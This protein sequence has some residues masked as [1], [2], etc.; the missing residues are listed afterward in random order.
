[1]E[2]SYRMSVRELCET[3]DLAT[4]LVLDPLL[5]FSTHKMNIS[6]PPE[7]RRWGYLR[8]TLLRFK[9]THDF[10]ATFD[11]LLDGE[12]VSGYFTGL[13]SHRQELLKQHM[14]RYMTAFLL[15]SGVN[16]EPCNRYSSETN[17]AKI[18]STRH[19]LVGE[20]VEVLQGCIAELS[21][22]DSAVLRAGVND[23]SV[24]Y[25]MRKRC[26]QLWLGPAAFI[27]HDCR[28]NCKFVPGDKNGACVKVVRPISPGDE[29]TCYYGDSFF[30]ENNEMC[31]C[32]TCERR[33]E[34]SFKKR[35][36]SPDVACSVDPS[37]Q[38]YEFRETDLRLN[39]NRGNG[40]PKPFLTVSNSALPMRNTFSQRTKRNALVLSKMR[41][42]DRWRREEQCKQVEKRTQNLLSSLPHLELKELSI[43]LYQH[44]TNFLLSCK[45]PLS[46]ERA[47]LYLTEKERPKPERITRNSKSVSPPL[48]SANI[49]GP[50]ERKDED[51]EMLN[52]DP[53]I[54]FK[55]FTL[56]CVSS[57]HERDSMKAKGRNID[58]SSV[59]IVHQGISSRTR[60]ILRSRLSSLQARSRS[61]LPRFNKRRTRLIKSNSKL[62]TG[63]N[64]CSDS[65]TQDGKQQKGSE[66]ES[67][68]N[69][70]P[71]LI[72]PESTVIRETQQRVFRDCLR[73][74][75]GDGRHISGSIAPRAGDVS[76]CVASETSGDNKQN[77][78]QSVSS[79][80]V[81]VTP[82]LSSPSLNSPVSLLSGLNRYLR[83]SLE[84]VAIPGKPEVE[85]TGQR[86]ADSTR[87][88]VTAP[89]A[90][91]VQQS[92]NFNGSKESNIQGKK[93][94]KELYFTPV[95][96]ESAE[97]YLKVTCDLETGKNAVTQPV[98]KE[99]VD[100]YGK[101]SHSEYEIEGK[102]DDKV[103]TVT[104]VEVTIPKNSEDAGKKRKGAD[105]DKK[106][107][108]VE[109][110]PKVQDK[111][112][113]NKKQEEVIVEGNYLK[114]KV[115]TASFGSRTVVV[116]E[117]R[118][119]LMDIRKSLSCK[120]SQQDKDANDHQPPC[121]YSGIGEADNMKT[122]LLADNKE[123]KD[124]HD[125]LNN[126]NEHP[127]QGLTAADQPNI[128]E[129]TQEKQSESA[130]I[131]SEPP[132]MCMV[133][134]DHSPQSSI[135]LKKRA[136]RESL[137]TDPEQDVNVPATPCTDGSKGKEPNSDN[138]LP[139][140]SKSS[141]VDTTLM[142]CSIPESSLTLK[143]NV[144]IGSIKR[145]SSKLI[146]TS[147]KQYCKG[148]QSTHR[149]PGKNSV[150]V[151]EYRDSTSKVHVCERT[152][153]DPK[154]EITEAVK[155][156]MGEENQAKSDKGLG[157]G[158]KGPGDCEITD[159]IEHAIKDE[160]STS[161]DLD[162]TEEE[163]RLN[164]R[165]RLKRKRGKEWAMECTDE[166]KSVVDQSS[167]QQCLA[168]VDP[169]SA[170]LDTVSILNAEM[171]RIRGH[172]EADNGVGLEKATKAVQDVLE[173]CRKECAAKP[174]KRQQKVSAVH[175]N[176]NVSTPNEIVQD[177]SDV[178]DKQVQQK[179]SSPKIEAD[180]DDIKPLPLIR[181]CRRAEGKWEV[182]WKEVQNE[183]GSTDTLHREPKKLT[184][185]FSTAAIVEQMPLGKVK[186]ENPSQCQQLM[187]GRSCTFRDPLSFET[188]PLPISLSLLSLYS[189][190]YD[191]LAGVSNVS[192][193]I[194]A[195]DNVREHV[196]DSLDSFKTGVIRTDN[197]GRDDI[198]LSHNLFQI[199]K[200]LS[201]LQALSQSQVCEK[202][203]PTNTSVTSSQ[204][205]SPSISPFTTECSFSN[206]SEDVLDFPCLN[207]E[208]YDQMPA[209]NNLASS[210]IDYCPGEPH[211]TGSFSS[212]FSQSPT[213]AWNPETP[214]LGSPSPVSNFSSGEELC[215][216]D[217]VF[218]QSDTSSSIGASQL[219]FKDKLCNTATSSAPLQDPEKDLYLSDGELSKTP[220][221]LQVQEDSATQFLPKD[222][223]MFNN[224]S[225]SAKQPGHSTVRIHPQDKKL[226]FLD[227]I[228]NTKSSES[229]LAKIDIKDKIHGPLNLHSS[230]AKSE[231]VFPNLSTQSLHGAGPH[232]NLVTPFHSLHVGNKSTSLADYPGAFNSGNALFRSSDKKLPFF[233][234]PKNISKTEEGQNACR[235]SVAAGSSK[236]HNNME[237]IYACP[238][239]SSS[240]SGK[241]SSARC[242][243]AE[244]SRL[245]ENL[246][247]KTKNIPSK[248]YPANPG[249]QG[250][251]IHPVY[252]ISSS[253]TTTNVFKNIKPQITRNDKDPCLPSTYLFSS[254]QGSQC[255][256]T[257]QSKP[258]RLE[259]PH[260]VV[261]P[262][263]NTQLS[264][265]SSIQPNKDQMCSNISHCDS[266]AFN[267]SSSLS[268]PASQHS[269]PRLGYRESSVPEVPLFKTQS[270][271]FE[272]GQPP[273]QSYVVNFT[274]D[275]S[276]TLGYSEDGGSLNYTGSGPANYTYH[277][278][279]EPS[280]TQGRLV[281]EACG[282]S[283]FSPSPSASRFAGSKVHGGQVSRDQQHQGTGTHPCNSLHFSTS[284]SQSTPITDRKPKRLRLV[285]TDGTVDLD[286]Q[287]AD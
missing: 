213:D 31:E 118:V 33:G 247:K 22:E 202:S 276:V 107:K 262:T 165:I 216:P 133:S 14:Y 150:R 211:N 217:I 17:G 208:S 223:T 215:F 250:D 88:K 27:N 48:S 193:S 2:G 190:C 158:N 163:Q 140:P 75:A 59:R 52:E 287:Y 272:H 70:N 271:T 35:D 123:T 205:Q 225:T 54:R 125:A 173:H 101:D 43:C 77:H 73:E 72:S 109:S 106:Q 116:K 44:S 83:V 170:I 159:N 244:F 240:H 25:S 234:N 160:W 6:P 219:L 12:W 96:M 201:K 19:W 279:M 119:L 199:N 103:V 195:K 141:S 21:P 5:G 138:L 135:P 191:G 207:L 188:S 3:D 124:K 20:R 143:D 209:Q 214:Y 203:V 227:S 36:Q 84:R 78:R 18:T 15:D 253:K 127:N 13:G 110:V 100:V 45:D 273:H 251:R 256:S 178:T 145:G 99:L 120:F 92:T 49:N 210:L 233:P 51:G 168:L 156:N 154:S 152:I 260:A 62:S 8:G 47:L 108:H 177:S 90:A 269:S 65:Q 115:L 206:Y 164:V 180:I 286:L 82:S 46:K 174:C 34:G 128:H 186:E 146:K 134:L 248:Q 221:E 126:K 161:D 259:K 32:C 194:Q 147:A 89:A 187:A 228:I 182:E 265:V 167:P 86:E 281:V 55:P 258:S 224:A 239:P 172:G 105:K 197:K 198:C 139:K 79:S 53:V 183:D 236:S 40:T 122:L 242:P 74:V 277:C 10:Q 257:T 4:S 204:V 114:K 196:S 245:A 60:N 113:S 95:N 61:K 97:K 66:V 39:R 192:G 282:P 246:Q 220:I 137:D 200:S 94:V 261:T 254:S 184:S 64:E 56:G 268:P 231:S 266:S 144:C 270:T 179:S 91:S 169:F 267:F 166:A 235:I 102:Q 29:I 93:G 274:G 23:F 155:C 69:T 283:N 111:E 38:K 130:L 16:I 58:A 1:M 131:S 85:R 11:A 136:F 24:M 241:E 50:E 30:G 81:S 237:S 263:Q 175:I 226:H 112:S 264:G 151:P 189:P 26:A 181:L 42:T 98:V 255:Y 222:L 87:D 28:P 121:S 149:G 218:A 67:K 80:A 243:N 275:H 142:K 280:G 284:H 132:S 68:D 185:V 278:L 76:S 148:L 129:D 212:P 9:R 37:G 153:N 285:V 230:K 176:K 117:A 171:E 57:V 249:Q 41:K 238:G 71:V 252:F 157:G 104:S 232:S 229:Y 63:Q 162:K 7:I